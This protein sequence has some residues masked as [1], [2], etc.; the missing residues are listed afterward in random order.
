[1]PRQGKS[2]G[3]SNTL[4]GLRKDGSRTYVPAALNSVT[5]ITDNIYRLADRSV[6]PVTYQNCGS[7]YYAAKLTGNGEL[8]AEGNSH[9]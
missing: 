2:G 6:T 3:A 9:A 8:N 5:V 7:N 4:R 1:M